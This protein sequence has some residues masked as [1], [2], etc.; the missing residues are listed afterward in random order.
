MASKSKL[1]WNKRYRKR[2]SKYNHRGGSPWSVEDSNRIMADDRPTDLELAKELG[3]TVNAIQHHRNRLRNHETYTSGVKVGSQEGRKPAAGARKKLASPTALRLVG[4]FMGL[5]FEAD[6]TV[7]A[8]QAVID[9]YRP[10][11]K[12]GILVGAFANLS[13]GECRIVEIRPGAHQ[14]TVQV[15]ATGKQ[16]FVPLDDIKRVGAYRREQGNSRSGER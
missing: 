7:E 9:Q 1:E 3:R 8:M 12:A 5:K 4:L 11:Y 16:R 13:I 2:G 15:V 14:A 10:Y 6:A